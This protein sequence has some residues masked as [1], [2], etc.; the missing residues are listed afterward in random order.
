MRK[1]VAPKR[2]ALVAYRCKSLQPPAFFIRIHR[3]TTKPLQEFLKQKIPLY[4]RYWQHRYHKRI[5]TGVLTAL[6]ITILIFG[7][8]HQAF[9]LS[10]WFQ[11]DWSGGVGASAVNQYSASANAVTTTS[12]QITLSGKANW[13][14]NVWQKRKLI[15][16]DHTKVTANQTNFPI[17]IKESSDADLVARAQSSGND[18]MFTDSNGTTKLAFQTESYD[19]ATGALV[20]WV[21]VPFLSATTDTTLYMYY[22]N[23]SAGVQQDPT[24]VWDSNYEGVWHLNSSGATLNTNDSTSKARNGTNTGATSTTSEVGGA[25]RFLGN[26]TTYIDAGANPITGSSPFTLSAWVNTTQATA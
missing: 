25:A 24:N 20:A 10:T 13:Y 15:T 18:I 3:K 5:N 26:G 6:F 14:N 12:N 22:G 21:K 9:A 17:L 4:N 1:I 2:L 11:N 7:Q 19:S 16:I 8:F 23:A